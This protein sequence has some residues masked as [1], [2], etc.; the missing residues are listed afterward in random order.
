MTYRLCNGVFLFLCVLI[1][2]FVTAAPASD[3]GIREFDVQTGDRIRDQV[4][5]KPVRIMPRLNKLNFG[6][7]QFD[8]LDYYFTTTISRIFFQDLQIS[9][10]F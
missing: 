7:G 9:K 2:G 4:K 3:E 8:G 1:I 6:F 10:V 5:G